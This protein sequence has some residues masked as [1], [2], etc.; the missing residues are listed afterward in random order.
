MLLVL[1]PLALLSYFFHQSHAAP[2]HKKVNQA[3]FSILTIYVLN[4]Y[5]CPPSKKPRRKVN[6]A[7][8]RC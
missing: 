3:L 4:T 8:R 1:V 7:R 6:Q 5:L 2:L